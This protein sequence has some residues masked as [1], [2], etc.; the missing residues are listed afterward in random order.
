MELLH[1]MTFVAVLLTV[2]ISSVVEILKICVVGCAIRGGCGV[3]WH[4][5]IIRP[6]LTMLVRLSPKCAVQPA[7]NSSPFDIRVPL[8]IWKKC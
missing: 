7:S 2:Y 8:G 4:V 1:M 3:R 6:V 5:R